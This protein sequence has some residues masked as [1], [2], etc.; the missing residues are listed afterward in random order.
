MPNY[1]PYNDN[2]TSMVVI[3]FKDQIQPGTFEHALHHLISERL[4]LSAFHDKYNNDS[5]GRSAYDPAILLK[6][7][8][9]ASSVFLGLYCPARN[10]ITGTSPERPIRRTCNMRNK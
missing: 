3:N 6:V 9:L 5:G 1:K 2:Q 4:D 10:S 7:I 8:L